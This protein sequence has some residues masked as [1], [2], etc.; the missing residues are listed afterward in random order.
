MARSARTQAAIVTVLQG[1]I[2]KGAQKAKINRFAQN[3]QEQ[4]I[5]AGQALV[6]KR[7]SLENELEDLLSFTGVSPKNGTGMDSV[8]ASNY[9]KR[10]VELAV[11]LEQL[12]LKIAAIEEAYKEDFGRDLPVVDTSFDLTDVAEDQVETED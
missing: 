1:L 8:S 11:E 2:G 5:Q 3:L 9:V 4:Y 6:N 12:G 7:R 10:R